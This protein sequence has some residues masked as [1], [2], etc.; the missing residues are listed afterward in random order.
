MYEHGLDFAHES[1]KPH[2]PRTPW[3]QGASARLAAAESRLEDVLDRELDAA[4]DDI[5]EDGGALIGSRCR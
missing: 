5:G 2:H 4:F 1:L 3:P